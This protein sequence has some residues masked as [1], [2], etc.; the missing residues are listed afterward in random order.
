LRTRTLDRSGQNAE[1]AESTDHR[2]NAR[3]GAFADVDLAE[4]LKRIDPTSSP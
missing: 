2:V 1:T 3:I 4:D